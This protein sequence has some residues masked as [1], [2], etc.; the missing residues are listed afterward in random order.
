MPRLS[1]LAIRASLLYLAAGFTLGALI[2]WHK[3][4]AL[5]PGLW[6]WLPVHREM[7]LLGWM[8]QLAMGVAYWILPRFS[9]GP[10]RGIAPLASLAIASLN[11]GILLTVS[12]IVAAPG[13]AIA[14]GRALEGFAVIA[15]AVHAWPRVRA[16]GA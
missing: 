2:L 15:F 16:F 11:A 10:P 8:A 4:A 14:A 1:V 7:L 6:R 3:G 9:R 5:D 13:T 12:P